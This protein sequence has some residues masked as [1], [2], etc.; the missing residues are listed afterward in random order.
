MFENIFRREGVKAAIVEGDSFHRYEREEFVR[1]NTE[2][3]ILGESRLSH[4]GP[5]AN[6]L[7]ELE[8]LF[9]TYGECGSGKRRY[10]CP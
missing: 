2:R 9:R 10:Y 1:I 6:L 5:E 3:A 7:K 4:F 8:N